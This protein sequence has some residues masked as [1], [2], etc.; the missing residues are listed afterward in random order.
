MSS[1]E[2]AFAAQHPQHYYL[3]RVYHEVRHFFRARSRR[4]EAVSLAWQRALHVAR[5]RIL[6]STLATV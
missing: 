5:M 4:N 3:Y 2:V 1:H 6:V